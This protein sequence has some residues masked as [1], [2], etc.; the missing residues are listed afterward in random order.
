MHT[1]HV[2]LS[3]R[4]EHQNQVIRAQVGATH[5]YPDWDTGGALS[6]E[7]RTISAKSAASTKKRDKDCTK[8]GAGQLACRFFMVM[9]GFSVS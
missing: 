2:A 5:E 4:P 8:A 9:S 1:A 6:K 3:P 7:E